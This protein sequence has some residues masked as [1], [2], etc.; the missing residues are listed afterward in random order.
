MA[1]I[2]AA[3]MAAATGTRVLCNSDDLDSIAEYD[4]KMNGWPS[5]VAA[6]SAVDRSADAVIDYSDGVGLPWWLWLAN[7]GNTRKFAAD[8]VTNFSLV[9]GNAEAW[10]KIKTL[11]G[12]WWVKLP[13]G[14]SNKKMIFHHQQ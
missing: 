4:A 6:L 13:A 7:T 12:T 3:R 9:I 5:I 11:N 14:N 1:A 8:G 10:I 2:V